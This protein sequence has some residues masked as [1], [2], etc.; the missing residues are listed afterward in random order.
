MSTYFTIWHYIALSIGIIVFFFT[1]FLAYQDKRFSVRSSIIIS[2]FFIN[3]FI[4]FVV[5]ISIDNYT[6]KA[7]IYN[8]KNHRL[9]IT[10]E[11]VYTGVVKNI[12][13]YTI[14]TVRLEIKLQNKGRAKGNAKRTGSYFEPANVI[15]FFGHTTGQIHAQF[16]IETPII[17]E[18]LQPGESRAFRVTFAYPP[19]FEGAK[20]FTKIISH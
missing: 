11:I 12:G 1:V 9:L 7:E 17:A 13:D 10:E 18:N 19:Y 14:G 2:S 16:L 5:I 8:L 4:G 3:L 15:H 20:Q 6:K